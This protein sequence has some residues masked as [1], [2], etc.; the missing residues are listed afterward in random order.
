MA[1]KI[2]P[3]LT[4]ELSKRVLDFFSKKDT[5]LTTLDE[6]IAKENIQVAEFFKSFFKSH[7]TESTTAGIFFYYLL[8]EGFDCY[9]P[10]VSE[11]T[12]NLIKSEMFYLRNDPKLAEKYTSNLIRHIRMENPVFLD[13][14]GA[15]VVNSKNPATT[16]FIGSGIYRLIEE[17]SRINNEF[18]K[19]DLIN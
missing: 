4:K 5:N 6:E 2:V 13:I 19:T 18:Y 7:S 3:T 12:A 8:R 16:F 15:F 17:Q 14:L 9:I 10:K 1:K 11:H